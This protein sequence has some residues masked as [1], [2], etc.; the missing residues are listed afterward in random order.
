MLGT[1]PPQHMYGL[2]AT[3]ML[4]LQNGM[5]GTLGRPL[6]PGDIAAALAETPSRALARHHSDPARALHR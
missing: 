2:E 1:V 4:P 6:L 3:I 5:A